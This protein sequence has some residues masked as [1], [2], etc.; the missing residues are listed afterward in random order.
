MRKLKTTELNRLST[1]EF[2]SAEKLPVIV[3][4]DNIRS[5]ANIGSVFR[6]CDAFLVEAIYL[7]GICAKP[8]NRDIQK[9]AL[10]AT[11]TV[12]WKYFETIK[13]CIAA[14]RDNKFEIL[15]VEQSD[16]SVLLN[17][18]VPLTNKKYALIFGN[19]VEGVS[20]FAMQYCDTCLEIPQ[21]G[22]KHSLNISVS[23]GI[24]IWEFARKLQMKNLNKRK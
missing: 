4:L 24:V 16:N 6:T 11:E 3:V 14:L 22:M 1:E 10:G 19:E 2:K 12:A 15:T 23:A 5:A 13:D 9:S 21:F 20:D 7:V 18:F 8:P 17:E